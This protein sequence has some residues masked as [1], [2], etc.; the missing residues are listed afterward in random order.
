MCGKGVYITLITFETFLFFFLTEN[1]CIAFL[2]IYHIHIRMD[3]MS[4]LNFFCRHTYDSNELYAKSTN[5]NCS[6]DI[7]KALNGIGT[8][9]YKCKHGK[10]FNRYHDL[11][12]LSVI[13]VPA[14][15]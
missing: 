12:F 10:I 8:D 2:H 14:N 15:G 11:I 13:K 7:L 3:V 4:K 1:H 9:V 5:N 6:G